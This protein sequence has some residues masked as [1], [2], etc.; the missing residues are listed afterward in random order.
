MDPDGRKANWS[1]RFRED[2]DD[3]TDRLDLFRRQKAKHS[4][5]LSTSTYFVKLLQGILRLKTERNQHLCI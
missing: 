2:G 1:E 5:S 3:R 4:S